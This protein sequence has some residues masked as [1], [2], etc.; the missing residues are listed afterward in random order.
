MVASVSVKLPKALEEKIR[1][2]AAGAGLSPEEAIESLLE[3][4]VKMR[5]IPGVYFMEGATGRRAR[6]IGG[7]DIWEVIG[8][9]SVAGKD[10]DVL[11]ASYPDTDE[12]I[13]RTALRYNKAYPEEIEARIKSNLYGGE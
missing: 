6:L 5:E 8:P 13:L 2:I 3:E 1:R 9:Y 7:I 12:E 10:W 11:R 4:P